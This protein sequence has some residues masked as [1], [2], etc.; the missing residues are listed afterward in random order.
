MSFKFNGII[1]ALITPFKNGKVD[2]KSLEKLVEY[3]LKNGVQGFV[4]NGT[5]AES[6]TLLK[7][8]V[9]T[10]FNTVKDLCEGKVPLILGT[11][12]NSTDMTI[13]N[14]LMAQRLNADAVLTVVPYYN[15]PTQA[16]LFQHFTAIA[17]A[18]SRPVFLYNVPSRTI[19]SLAEETIVELSKNAK[20]IGI[21]EASGNIDF[22]HKLMENCRKDFIFLSGDDSTFLDFMETGGH[23]IISV[24]SNL[25][26]KFSRTLYEDIIG[27]NPEKAHSEFKRHLNLIN[28]MYVEANPIPIKWMLWKK[29]LIASPEMRLPM[30]TL[31]PKHY[32]KIEALMKE[33]DLI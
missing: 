32:E 19:T 5:T 23:G 12:S 26:S 21:K 17:E 7:D 29:N 20:I 3:Q 31:E 1:S 28:A 8:E 16:G 24:M 33:C 2:Y 9:E 15:K 22:D 18:S 27:N 10:I 13:A 11:G 25:L 14:N 6:P 30:T 4:I